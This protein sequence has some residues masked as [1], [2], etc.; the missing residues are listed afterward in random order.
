MRRLGAVAAAGAS[1]DAL[2]RRAG[3]VVVDAA[4]YCPAGK[5]DERVAV[6]GTPPRL[7][8]DVATG[9]PAVLVVPHRFDPRWRARLAGAA[10]AVLD[11]SGLCAVEVPAGASTLALDMN[12]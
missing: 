6:D 3:A 9:A 4:L 5:P 11:A 10:I 8:Y 12:M 2:R 7:R 1:L